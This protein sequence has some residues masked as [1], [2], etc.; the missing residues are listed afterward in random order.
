MPSSYLFL[1]QLRVHYL[2]W[3]H[4]GSGIPVVLLHALGDNARFWERV[5]PR[6]EEAGLP[7]V[8]PD[9]CCHGL[10]D[11]ADGELSTA[12]FARN[13]AAFL[14]AIHAD[15]PLLVGHGW[16]A[17]LAVDYGA[18]LSFGPR[19][20]AGLVLVEG[21]WQQDSS[22]WEHFLAANTPRWAGTHLGEFL[23]Q[24]PDIYDG[25]KPDDE[26]VA[27]L[28]SNFAIQE[29]GPPGEN[30]DNASHPG[31]GRSVPAGE[32][33]LPAETLQPLLS[34]AHRAQI[35]GLVWKA[36]RFDL[37]QKIG[38]P[39]RMVLAEASASGAFQVERRRQKDRSVEQARAKIQDFQEHWLEGSPAALPLQHP[40]ELAELIARFATDLAENV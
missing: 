22:D 26:A 6:L 39:V 27:I 21:G 19:R 11:K 4:S 2:H 29:A 34:D 9:A 33:A 5:G 35:L 38:C 16:G 8:A 25:W 17:D 31:N 14:D 10:T 40:A 20:P 15:H 13:L 28:L 18:R 12:S 7:A 23:E 30:P 36:R 24:V 3:N 32:A 1:N 37:Y